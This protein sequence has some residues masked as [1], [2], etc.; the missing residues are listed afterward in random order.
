MFLFS[1][2]YLKKIKLQEQVS[3]TDSNPSHVSSII[4]DLQSSLHHRI[5]GNTQ[6]KAVISQPTLYRQLQ[7]SL[8]EERHRSD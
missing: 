5:T 2:M 1:L 7:F 6:Y 4:H 8:H 3:I